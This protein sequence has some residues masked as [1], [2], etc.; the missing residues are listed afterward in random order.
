MVGIECC[1]IRGASYCLWALSYGDYLM[2]FNDDLT[3]QVVQQ[4]PLIDLFEQS[5]NGY[6]LTVITGSS[7]DCYNDADF[8]YH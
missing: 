5:S 6:Y 7:S 3:S 2:Q 1:L 8:C 4:H